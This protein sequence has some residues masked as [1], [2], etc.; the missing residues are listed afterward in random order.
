VATT[1]ST[2]D[3]MVYALSHGVAHRYSVIRMLVCAL[4][5]AE[6]DHLGNLS[7]QEIPRLLP[8]W[9]FTTVDTCVGDELKVSQERDV[10]IR[11]R[12]GCRGGFALACMKLRRCHAL[13]GPHDVISQAYSSRWTCYIA[14]RSESSSL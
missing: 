9:A 13:T 11:D 1:S 10:D 7:C 2:K 4:H 12:A 14:Q 6:D 8:V 3:L 5:A